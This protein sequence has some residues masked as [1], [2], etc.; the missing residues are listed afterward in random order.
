MAGA[1][2][3]FLIDFTGHRLASWRR[4][5]VSERQATSIS[6]NE[7]AP[8]EEAT[9]GQSTPTV[10]YLANLSHHHDN[11][12]TTHP[13]D[14]V[15]VLILEGGIIFHSLLLG[16]TLVVAGDSVFI[17]LFIVIMF[18]QMFEGLAL[19]AR[20]AAIEGLKTTK[21][22][23]LPMA[24][25]LVTPTGMA[26]GI[27][28]LNKFNGNSPSTIIALG[29]LDAIS[30]GILL[31]VGF[32]SMWAHDWM[33]GELRDAGLTRTLAALISLITGLALMGLLGKWA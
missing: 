17:T 6:S 33:F 26:I 20:I 18:H 3:A 28:V 15:S 19:G 10:S 21:Y 23:V 31:W 29:T 5:F 16:I 32:V 14:A 8:G 24:F 1:F 7:G 25:A 12:G 27:G 9:K 30:A 11:L 2:I 22:I 4:H 13:K